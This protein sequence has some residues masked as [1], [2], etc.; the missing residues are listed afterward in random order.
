MAEALI[1]LGERVAALEELHP[2]EDEGS[3]IG[4]RH[5]QEEKP[6]A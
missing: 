5:E 4:F 1:G 6:E 3:A 2:R